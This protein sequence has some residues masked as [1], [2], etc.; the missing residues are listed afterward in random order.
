MSLAARWTA[1]RALALAWL[2]VVLAIAAHQWSFWRAPALDTD[3]FALLPQDEQL[4]AA[5]LAM[6]RLAEQGER[7]VV[8]A[9]G[10]ADWA[11]AQ[12]A[13]QRFDA[14]LA[15]QQVGLRATPTA[16]GMDQALAFFRPWRDALLTDA[17]R[18]QLSG[19]TPDAWLGRALGRLHGVAGAQPTSWLEDPAGLWPDWWSQ[20]AQLTAARPRDGGLW[21]HD[22]GRDWAVLLYE[23]EGSAFRLDGERRWSDALDQAGAAARAGASA[24]DAQALEILQAGVPLHAEAGAAQGSRE[25]NTIGWGSLLAVVL[26]VWWTFRAVRPVALIAVSLLVGCAAA[27]S[28]TLLVFGRVHVLTLVFGAS[29]VGVAED[30]GIHYFASRLA[31]PKTERWALMKHL[32]PGLFL[33]MVT[34]VLGYLVLAVVPF[35][36][37]R[38][39]ALFSAVGM[40]AAMLTAVCWFPFLDRGPLP[41]SRLASWIAASLQRW[42]RLSAR[43]LGSVL[44]VFTLFCAGGLYRVH[45]SDDLRQLQSS[46]AEL[47]R[48]QIALGRLLQIPSPAQFFVLHGES[49]EALLQ[50]EEALKA[51]LAPQLAQF[52]TQGERIGLSA[53]S[54]WVPSAA[55]QADNRRLTAS[56]E[57]PLLQQLG[58]QLG[59]DLQRP[60]FAAEPLAL[61][62]WLQ[63]PVSQGMRAQ[64]LGQV[65]DDYVSVVLIRGL[66]QRAQGQALQ[67]AGEQV[68]GV[69]W[70]DRAADV[71]SLLGRFRSVIG[72]LLVLGHA[73]VWVALALRYGRSAWRAW[74]P[75]VLA[76]MACVA[77]QGWLGEP[78][79]LF[80]LLALMLLLGVG[81]DYGIFLLE[82][83]GDEQGHAWL[84]VLMGA[85]S[86]GLSFGLLALSATPALHAYGLTLL[87]GLVTVCVLAPF[88]RL[89]GK[90]APA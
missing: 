43:Q 51:A 40:A 32:L 78:F 86:T 33:A 34:S 76:S 50:R 6:Q 60:A 65:G 38:Q 10:A 14:Y 88:F 59:E 45:V 56:I 28:V 69:R 11:S 62:Q 85:L 58:R 75:T 87:V 81:V 18:Q 79:Q 20:R 16:Q 66:S 72:W 83:Q 30:F 1:P 24:A 54:D 57:A 21:V 80:N 17:Q 82:H 39:M 36:G 9:L 55:R 3:V 44:A 71:S 48:A 73:V 29:L 19:S 53:I 12:A 26:L 35:P 22:G 37:L 67:A 8:V 90:A 31:A 64:W 42:P 61:A 63:S 74:I 27:L 25:M 13:A 70:V 2:L 7:R 49:P 52:N 47:V 68:P 5:Q 84:A 23:T 4:P 15:T 77:V 89:Q 46:P 41:G